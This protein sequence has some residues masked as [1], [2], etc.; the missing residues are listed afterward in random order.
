MAE[1]YRVEVAVPVWGQLNAI[2]ID[3]AL[4]NELWRRLEELAAE[5]AEAEPPTAEPRTIS[6]G[7]LRAAYQLSKSRRTLTLQAIALQEET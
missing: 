3:T 6:V 2:S 1:P 5:A 7:P 4:R